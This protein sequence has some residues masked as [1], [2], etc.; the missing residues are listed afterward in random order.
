[1]LFCV[2]I[3]SV[4]YRAKLARK[5][6]RNKYAPELEAKSYQQPLFITLVIN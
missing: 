3:H 4:L 1:M 2:I 6:E 5:S